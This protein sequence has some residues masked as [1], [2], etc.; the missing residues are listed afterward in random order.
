[1][2]PAVKNPAVSV[3]PM[4]RRLEA[5]SLPPMIIFDVTNTC[6]LQCIHCPQ[7]LI[8]AKADFKSTHLKWEHFVKIA[9]EVAAAGHTCLL[10][11]AGDGE[12]FVH[13]RMLDMIAYAKART[14]AVV[15]LT[16]NG[17]LMTEK[18]VDAMLEAG[19]D[20]IDISIDGLTKPTYEAVRRGG[21]FE[22][23][24]RNI[25]YLLHQRT[26]ARKRTKLMVSFISQKE[27]QHEADGFRAFWAP[28]VDYVMVR[29][30]HSALGLVKVEESQDFNK[31]LEQ[32]RYPCPHLWKRLT[33]DFHGHIKFCAHDWV[34]HD[35]TKLGN[36]ADM[37]LGEAWRG[38]QLRQLRENHKRNAF[39]DNAICARC[40]DWAS[41]KWDYGYERLVDRVVYG[42]PQLMPE[43]PPLE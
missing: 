23:L 32:H 9:D 8:Q 33:V 17:V 3:E 1:M 34:Y 41:A 35:E 13:P 42:R 5:A 19:I 26:G 12:P 20:L 39:P 15:N 14:K 18:R 7:P 36:I 10:R 4:Q 2:N 16:T 6:N 21:N 27:N 29:N 11:F 38:E 30:L 37:T 40:T 28:L 43:L 31:A 22:R 24:M 25:F